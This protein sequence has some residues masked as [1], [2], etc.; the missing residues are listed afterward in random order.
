MAEAG[1]RLCQFRQRQQR[2]RRAQR[3]HGR[4]RAS[5]ETRVTGVF[6]VSGQI[7]GARAGKGEGER[8]QNIAGVRDRAGEFGVGRVGVESVERRAQRR[9]LVGRQRAGL[10]AR[11]RL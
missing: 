9:L 7:V 8:Q 3:E 11:E 5:A 4:E 1:R 2:R 6:G 10:A